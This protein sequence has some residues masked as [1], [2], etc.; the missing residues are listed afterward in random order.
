MN[1]LKLRFAEGLYRWNLSAG[2]ISILFSALTFVGIFALAFDLPWYALLLL[3]SAVIL[4]T[5]FLLDRVIKIWDAQAKVATVRNP[6]L[7]D[8]LYQKE[9]LTL[10]TVHLPMLRAMAEI[11]VSTHMNNGVIADLMEAIARLEATVEDKRWSIA[12]GEDVYG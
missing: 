4:G 10:T 1:G 11:A 5:G 3:V 2:I 8:L 12:P 7:V 9:L 6:W